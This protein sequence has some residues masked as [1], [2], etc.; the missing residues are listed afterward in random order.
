MKLGLILEGGATILSQRTE[1]DP[2][3]LG[4]LYD[5]GYQ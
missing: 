4:D 5:L 2:K 3:I 1:V